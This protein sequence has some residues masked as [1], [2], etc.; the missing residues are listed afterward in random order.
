MEHNSPCEA[1]ISSASQEISHILWNPTVN[2]R[3]HNST[4]LVPILRQITPLQ[5]HFISWR[6]ILTLFS[7]LH[8]GLPN[9][10]LPSG[11]PTKILYARLLSPM[12]ATC[13]VSLI[14]LDFIN[15]ISFGKVFRSWISALCSLL[16]FPLGPDILLSTLFSNTLCLCFS[17]SL[18]DHV[19]HLYISWKILVLNIL[20][21]MFLISDWKREESGPNGIRH[22]LSSICS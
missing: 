7:N 3:V 13:P 20:V 22:F 6:S 19:L 21:V 4:P 18:R 17:L 11:F 14:L 16:Q 12:F 1:K 15:R 10:L 8:L 5:P 9:G 2:Y